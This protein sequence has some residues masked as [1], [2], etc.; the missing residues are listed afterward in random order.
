MPED[1]AEL[2]PA[3]EALQALQWDDEDD[4]PLGTEISGKTFSVKCNKSES[5]FTD[6]ND[7]GL[8]R[9]NSN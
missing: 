3:M 7:F 4:T 1:G 2:H 6:N 9:R 5:F 8:F